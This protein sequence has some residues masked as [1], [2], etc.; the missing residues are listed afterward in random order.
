MA[1]P[2]ADAGLEI[3]DETLV[4]EIIQGRTENFGILY[5]RYFKR[6]HRFVSRRMA[7]TADVDETV[8]EVFINVLGSLE[9]F[10]GE[11][12]FAAWVFGLTRR[13]IANRY[14]RKR[15]ETVPLPSD[16]SDAGLGFSEAIPSENDPYAS[17]ERNERL[18]RI[19][20]GAERL[21]S[22]QWELFRLHHLEHRSI[23]DIA[24]ATHK[25][26]DA[27]KSHL[28]RARKLLLAR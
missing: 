3:T 13:T 15:A 26:R 20:R 11:A 8:Q 17:Y 19:Q 9:S 21:S 4:E 14:K 2:E 24:S 7:N 22:D 27:V 6:I 25:S 10:R 16:E 1:A 23:E 12:P 5:E 18:Y 28:Y